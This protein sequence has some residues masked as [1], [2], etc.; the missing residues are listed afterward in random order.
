MKNPVPFDS[1]LEKFMNMDTDSMSIDQLQSSKKELLEVIESIEKT[2]TILNCA[3]EI[4]EWIGHTACKIES[5]ECSRVH[6]LFEAIKRGELIGAELDVKT[7]V[8]TD[9]MDLSQVFV[10]KHDWYGVLAEQVEASEGDVMLPYDQCIF[11]MV[12]N[13]RCVI[14]WTGQTE[15]EKPRACPFV[16]IDGKWYCG[17]EVD[18]FKGGP[19][20][21]AWLQV[22]GVCIA[23]DAEVAT[24]EV[25][26]APVAL[27]KKRESNG[28]YPLKDFHVVDLS[29]RHRVSTGAPSGTHKSPRM[30]FRRGHWR[31]FEQS[32]T[33]IRWMLVGNPDLGF[34]DKRYR[35]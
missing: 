1:R 23:L 21:F 6:Q 27:N 29:K 20:H 26:R 7:M 18:T 11:E 8:P 3:M 30:H 9:A 22:V 2:K 35:L 15:G 5:N 16:Q 34:V 4:K 14:V 10:V 19:L 24:H 12:I 32:R 13:G 31:H 25:Q 33:W 17:S 28:K